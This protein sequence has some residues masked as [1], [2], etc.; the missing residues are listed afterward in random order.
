MGNASPGEVVELWSSI[1][2]RGLAVRLREE[3][4]PRRASPT[5]SL[6]AHGLTKVTHWPA[7][8]WPPSDT[9]LDFHIAGLTLDA[10]GGE[11]VHVR[12]PQGNIT[13]SC[14]NHFAV[15]LMRRERAGDDFA[16]S[17]YF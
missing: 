13:T 9:I 16:D 10:L 8:A 7:H 4:A 12:M 17:V 14:R 3:H 5:A 2:W 6:M 1:L 15:R 11:L